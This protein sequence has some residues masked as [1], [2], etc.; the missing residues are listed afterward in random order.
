MRMVMLWAGFRGGKRLM[1]RGFVAVLTVLMLGLGWVS[2]M[3]MAIAANLPILLGGLPP[4]NAVT[5]GKAILRYALPLENGAVREL[6]D[7][8]E[9][10]SSALRSRRFPAI[11]RSLDQA[12]KLLDRKHDVLIDAVGDSKETA[13]SLITQIKAD[14]VEMRG[15]VEAKNRDLIWT[16]RRQTLDHIGDL[17]G[18]MVKEFHVQIPEKYSELPYLKGRATVEMVTSRGTML[19]DLDGYNAPVTAG[20]FTDLIKRKFYDG[21]SFDRVEDYYFLQAGHPAGKEEGFIDPKTKQYRAIPLEYT[22]E[23]DG[24]PTY[25]LTPEDTGRYM[26]KVTLPFSSYGTLAMARPDDNLNGGSSQFF[27]FLFEPE[28]TPAGANLLDGRYSVFGYVTENK[29][30]L[31]QLKQGDKIISMKVVKGLENLVQP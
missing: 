12:E 29:E 2:W 18:L 24:K 4:G 25:E 27:F 3:P 19:L 13:E 22:M 1:G 5:D 30:L 7:G 11:S 15:S 17:E 6:Q 21:L 20:N 8:F 14:I 26:E 16:E 28:L 31:G 9:G 10:M 23:G